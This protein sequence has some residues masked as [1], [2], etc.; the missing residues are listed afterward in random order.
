MSLI[1]TRVQNFRQEAPDFDKNMTRPC[2]YGALDFFVE[3]TDSGRSFITPR[4]MERAF[5][6]IG[7]T[8]QIPVINY[9][10]TV[11]V[12][13]TRVCTIADAENTSA[14][15]TVA[16]ATYSVGFTMVPT[17]YQNNDIS[18]QH[19]FNRK[20]EKVIRAMANAIDSAAVTTL[21]ANKTQV[22]K[23][24]LDYDHTGNVVHSSWEDRTEVIGDLN[25]LMR[26]NCYP[27]QIHLVGNAGIEATMRKLAQLGAN[28][29]INKVLEYS[30]KTFSYTNNVVD[31]ANKYG[32]A[33]AV[34]DGNVGYLT[35]SGRENVAQ[36]RAN[37]HEWD[38]VNL[39]ILN[40]PVDTHYY[41]EVG[42]QSA[43]AGAS[44][45]D[46]TCN[47]KEYFGFMVDIAF[48]VSYNSDPTTIPNPII[49]FD[50][51]SNTNTSRAARPVVVTNGVD[52]PIY[53]QTT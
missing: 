5:N 49:E 40:I 51:A 8:L 42:D 11:Q 34:V 50:I 12:G 13:N 32:T 15:Y 37:F 28:N 44:S 1:A 53:T 29:A 23:N 39:P 36:T 38:V 20:F 21:S 4:L 24:D 48:L 41:T 31:E 43:I 46:M 45:E 14:L 18:Y 7:T 9:D 52:N 30:D 35:R 16:F 19:D 17:L 25:S 2:E 47:V 3:Q 22:F 6:S 26:A 10:G 33:Y 27:G